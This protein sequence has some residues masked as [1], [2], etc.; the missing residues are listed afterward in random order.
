MYHMN[1]QQVV[2][3]APTEVSFEEGRFMKE[4]PSKAWRG[5]LNGCTY[6]Y[7]CVETKRR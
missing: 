6:V 2:S 7:I 1:F 3:V 5:Q 4:Y